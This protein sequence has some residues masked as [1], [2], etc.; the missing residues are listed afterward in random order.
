MRNYFGKRLNLVNN[1]DYKALWVVNF[2]MFEKDDNGNPT[3][4]HHPFTMPYSEDVEMLESN[5][6]E[7]RSDAYDLCINGFEIAGGSVRI[8]ESTLQK[9]IFETIGISSE[10]AD[11]RFGFFLEALKYGVPPH[12]GIAFGFDRLIMLLTKMDSIRDVIAFPKTTAAYSLMENAPSMVDSKQL[13]E[14]HIS[15]IESKDNDGKF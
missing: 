7:V 10:K 1:D 2:P 8:H 6:F 9:K 12:G 5:P 3:P 11:E 14:L 13:E 4:M 15:I